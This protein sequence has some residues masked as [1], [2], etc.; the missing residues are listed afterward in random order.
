VD[1]GVAA[2]A[3][4][5]TRLDTAEVGHAGG[6]W[7]PHRP[8]HRISGCEI[9]SPGLSGGMEARLPVAR[10]SYVACARSARDRRV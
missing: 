9:A 10:Q 1:S 3:A 8:E 7:S 5:A 6:R 4:T 2:T